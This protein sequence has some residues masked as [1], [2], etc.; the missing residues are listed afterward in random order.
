MSEVIDFEVR[1]LSDVAL[2]AALEDTRLV[3]VECFGD[4][5]RHVERRL[6][7]RLFEEWE[8]RTRTRSRN[9]RGCNS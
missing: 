7:E 2:L 4:E 9:L 8:R 3:L 5:E 6:L 1:R